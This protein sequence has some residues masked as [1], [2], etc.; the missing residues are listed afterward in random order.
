[1]RATF[2]MLLCAIGV[3][4]PAPSVS[5]DD[6]LASLP[7]ETAVV[8]RLASPDRYLGNVQNLLT[9]V[10]GPA[11]RLAASQQPL[12][13]QLLFGRQADLGVVDR[14]APAYVVVLLLPGGQPATARFVV[15]PDEVALRR[16]ALGAV[17]G[18]ELVVAAGPSGFERVTSGDRS[19][20][21][22][23][24]AGMVVFTDRQEVAQLLAAPTGPPLSEACPAAVVDLLT[25]GDVGLLIHASHLVQ[26]YAPQI[27]QAEAD[28][29]QGISQIPLESTGS[30]GEQ[31]EHLRKAIS[32][33]VR[34]GFAA[35]RDARWGGVR[36]NLATNGVTVAVLV[37]VAEGSATAA[38]LAAN[39]ASGLDALGLLP[40]GSPFYYAARPLHGDA[41]EQLDKLLT[42]AYAQQRAESPE[43]QAVRA[44]A[45]QL[46]KDSGLQAIAGSFG[47]PLNASTGIIS[48]T[49]SEA[50]N[51]AALLEARAKRASVVGEVGT[52]TFSERVEYQPA[53]EALDGRPVDLIIRRF[54]AGTG[55]DEQTQIV[56]ALVERM[57]GG[58]SLQT[59]LTVLEGVL[60]EATGNDPRYLRQLVASLA[61]G[62]GLLGL[63][64]SFAECRDALAPQANVLI[65]LNLP[66]LLVD[67]VRML[68]DVP[69]FNMVFAQLP[70]NFNV[71]PGSS[72]SGLSL[73]AEEHALRIHLHV[74]AAHPRALMQIFALGQ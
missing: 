23:R 3:A 60:A 38:L 45:E 33:V 50:D 62:E 42:D 28:V 51:P 8:L 40:A 29:L 67:A 17:Q 12:L 15:A 19:L 68:R 22:G 69:P 37:T 66:Q 35:V 73:T 1:M 13:A 7:S 5:A 2:T 72:Y 47:L 39:P 18:Q 11:G 4:G 9:S 43:A 20:Y 10:G 25:S 61:S 30:Q 32:T 14:S 6:V 52:A 71:Q 56:K 54:A 64:P 63:D 26:T 55:Q 31:A 49:L 16:A 36:L 41:L 46:V 27:A 53:A 44:Q 70:F 58:T 74:S 59:R 65:M 24:R 34:G 48:Y 57:Y 21:F